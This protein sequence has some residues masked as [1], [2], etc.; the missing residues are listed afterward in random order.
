MTTCPLRK[1]VES[2][3]ITL[4]DFVNLVQVLKD[5]L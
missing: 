4:W 1:I 5:V 3:Y 2:I